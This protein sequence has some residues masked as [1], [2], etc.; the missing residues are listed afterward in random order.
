MGVGNTSKVQ[1]TVQT[2]PRF[3]ISI[4]TLSWYAR[5]AHRYITHSVAIVE[6]GMA[7]SMYAMKRLY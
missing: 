2:C 4:V 1:T 6:M 3:S 7:Q 5:R